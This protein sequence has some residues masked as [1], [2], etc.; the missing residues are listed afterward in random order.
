M[1]PIA[2]VEKTPCFLSIAK[3]EIKKPK[4]LFIRGTIP[5]SMTLPGS[6]LLCLPAE[7]T[8]DIEMKVE[9]RAMRLIRGEY[10]IHKRCV[11]SNAMIR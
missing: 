11:H 1:S 7:K 8:R 5:L 10:L 4:P 3:S 9:R 2:T 6:F